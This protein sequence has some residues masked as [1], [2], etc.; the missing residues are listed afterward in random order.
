MQRFSRTSRTLALL[1]DSWVRGSGFPSTATGHAPT[2]FVPELARALRERFG[3]AGGGWCGLSYTTA[4]DRRGGAAEPD[5][6]SQ[7]GTGNWRTNVRNQPTPDICT[8]MSDTPG[9]LIRVTWRGEATSAV[10]LHAFVG[11][12][13][14]YRWNGGPWHGLTLGGIAGQ[15]RYGLTDFPTHGAWELDIA[16]AQGTVTLSG[17]EHR[18]EVPG[19][20]GI[21]VHN[22][23]AGGSTT[24]DWLAAMRSGAWFAGAHSLG[25]DAAILLLGTNDQRD[26][27]ARVYGQNLDAIVDRLRS[28]F[29]SLHLVLACSPENSG[30]EPQRRERPM[31]AYQDAAAKVAAR[32]E[33]AIVD[34]QAAFGDVADYGLEGTRPLLDAS[35]IHPNAAGSAVL[36]ACMMDACLA[37]IDRI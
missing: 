10:V 34:L 19:K 21:R 7:A 13:I 24:A 18:A 8:S 36:R 30:N 22:L 12:A 28:Q 3:D 29:P 2:Y 15:A 4:S 17:I 37:L 16:V 32:H 31:T 33:L 27:D 23:G 11:G 6:L 1:G 5:R 14:N 25:L 9:D 20:P 26:F 35:R